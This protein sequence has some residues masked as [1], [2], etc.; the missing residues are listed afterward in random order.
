[1]VF[2]DTYQIPDLDQEYLEKLIKLLYGVES[3]TWKSLNSYDDKN[4]LIQNC[5]FNNVDGSSSY[6]DCVLKITNSRDSAVPN[7]IGIWHS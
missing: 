6:I 3:S 7:M 1:M 5:R 4:F 2:N